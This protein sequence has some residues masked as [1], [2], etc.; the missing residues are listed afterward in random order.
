M[1]RC[2]VCLE[3]TDVLTEL[4]EELQS[5]G[6]HDVCDRCAKSVA[7]AFRAANE[8]INTLRKSVKL[9][10]WRAFVNRVRSLRVG[11]RP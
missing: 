6:L 7:E 3:E 1:R 11:D 4:H 2:D 10:V 9:R 5:K 8:R